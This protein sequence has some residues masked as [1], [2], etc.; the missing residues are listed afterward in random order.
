VFWF[1]DWLGS[2]ALSCSTPALFSHAIDPHVSVAAV[3]GD[4][5][6]V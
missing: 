5:L 3:I 2:G 6:R 4:G 1:Y